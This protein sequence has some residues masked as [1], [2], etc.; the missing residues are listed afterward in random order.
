MDR[1]YEFSIIAAILG[2]YALGYFTQRSKYEK[3]LKEIGIRIEELLK[4]QDINHDK[5]TKETGEV[6]L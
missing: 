1:F 5:D 3:I 2:V 6:D 4:R